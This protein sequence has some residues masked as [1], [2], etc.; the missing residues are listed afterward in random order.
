MANQRR[1]DFRRTQTMARHVDHIVNTAGDPVI[2]I[3]IAAAAVAGEVGA[4]VSGEIGLH[5]ARV[6]AVDRAHLAGPAVSQYQIA[7]SFACQDSALV[8]HHSRPDAKERQRRRAGLEFCRAGQRRDQNAAGLGLPPGIHH[9][10][11][12]L[13]DNAVIPLPRLRVYR[14]ADR[15]QQPQR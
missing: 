4:F 15:S 12:V 10:A 1:L 6:V 2:A 3:G 14:L 11:F 5:E 13:A 7:L 8:I 9:R